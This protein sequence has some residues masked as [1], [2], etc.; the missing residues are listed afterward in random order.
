[1]IKTLGYFIFAIMATFILACVVGVGALEILTVY[2][3]IMTTSLLGCHIFM[4]RDK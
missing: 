4:G 2:N 1:M 3:G